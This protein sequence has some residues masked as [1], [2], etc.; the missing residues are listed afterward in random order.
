MMFFPKKEK[1]NIVIKAAMSS[2]L[3]L[4]LNLLR[5]YRLI[6]PMTAALINAAPMPPSSK[7]SVIRIVGDFAIFK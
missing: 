1:P 4:I 7:K 6:K 3:I 2:P 5:R